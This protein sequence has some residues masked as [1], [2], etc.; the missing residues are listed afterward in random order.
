MH[1]VRYGGGTGSAAGRPY[2]TSNAEG[3]AMTALEQ[4]LLDA[5]QR[6]ERHYE[7]RDAAMMRRLQSL[8][9]RLDALSGQVEQLARALRQLTRGTG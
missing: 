1:W 6:L 7:E 4:Q 5:L 2:R 8:T 9:A 3:E